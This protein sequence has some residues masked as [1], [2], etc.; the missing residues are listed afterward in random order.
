M[1][2]FLRI[3]VPLAAIAA[4]HPAWIGLGLRLIPRAFHRDVL[5][6]HG[7]WIDGLGLLALSVVTWGIYGVAFY[8]FLLSLAPVP[9]AALP[10]AA[11]VNALSFVAGSVAIVAP[12][13]LGVKEAA[14]TGLLLP[15][16]LPGV[17]A[18]MAVLAR[19]WSIVAD[20][21]LAGIALLLPD[22]AR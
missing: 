18:V 11:G 17:A 20:L 8:L 7:R 1:A 19:F 6:W 13:G 16:L 14:M 9:L 3:A 10:A 4:M 21:V 22:R 12:G 2:L 15:F 5:G